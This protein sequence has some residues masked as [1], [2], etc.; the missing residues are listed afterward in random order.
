MNEGKLREIVGHAIGAASMCWANVE[1][2]GVFDSGRAAL[3]IDLVVRAI[4]SLQDDAKRSS[5]WDQEAITRWASD[6]FG[7]VRSNLSIAVRANEEMA[8]LLACL[9][10]DD[11]DPHAR[12][13]VADVI[14]TLCRLVSRLGGSMTRDVHDKMEVNVQRKW[15]PRGNGM[16]DHVKEDGGKIAV[17]SVDP[18]CSGI[19]VPTPTP[20][21]CSFTGGCGLQGCPCISKELRDN[22]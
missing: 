3:L 12:V 11:N 8:E 9:S 19:W 6:T 18:S 5:K 17:P 14:I 20:I 13:E 22:G 7:E 2:A 1:R 21:W 15:R 10:L 4:L 16:G